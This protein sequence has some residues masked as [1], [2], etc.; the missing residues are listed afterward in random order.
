[1]SRLEEY[2]R[3]ADICDLQSRA[4]KN[5]DTRDFWQSAGESY[6]VLAW[7]ETEAELEQRL[8]CGIYH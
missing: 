4:A 3:K 6:R 8:R 2:F 7:L 1:M 5:P